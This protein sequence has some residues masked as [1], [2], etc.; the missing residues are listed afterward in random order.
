MK[1]I[2]LLLFKNA[3]SLLH[4]EEHL[5][6]MAYYQNIGHTHVPVYML[7]YFLII[8]SDSLPKDVSCDSLWFNVNAYYVVICVCVCYLLYIYARR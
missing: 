6:N 2:T 7:K 8:I 1:N 4:S 3:T 5:L